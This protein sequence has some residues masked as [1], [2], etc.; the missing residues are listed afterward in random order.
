M[1]KFNVIT[2]FPNL[3]EEHFNNLFVSLAQI[4]IVFVLIAGILL[5]ILK[6]LKQKKDLY[7]LSLIFL[8][9]LGS[10]AFLS[11][12]VPFSL[13][14]L[15]LRQSSLLNQIFRA[16]L[17]KFIVPT[18][19]AFS[20][21]LAIGAQKISKQLKQK[22]GKFWFTLPVGLALAILFYA[23]PVFTGNLFYD[24]M[25]VTI[26]QDY[27][28][29]IEF[30]KDK[31]KNARIANLPQGGFWGWTFYRWGLRGSGFL[32]YGI[33][34][35]ILDRAFDVWS[36]KNEQYYWELNYALQKKDSNL[37][38]Q[39][40]IKYQVKYV[41]FDDNV[42][43]PGEKEYA[44]LSLSTK[45]LLEKSDQ[46]KKTISFG[47]IDLYELDSPTSPFLITPTL[48]SVSSANFYTKDP[49]FVR[50][51]HYQTDN[52]QPDSYYPFFNL[53]TNRFQTERDFE[54]KETK[55][56]WQ[57]IKKLPEFATVDNYSFVFNP[58]K[59]SLLIPSQDQE[60]FLYYQILQ[61]NNQL[62]LKIPKINSPWYIEKTFNENSQI[63]SESWNETSNGKHE[64]SLLKENDDYFV[65]LI[66][67]SDDAVLSF[68]FPNL[69]LKNSWLIEID[70]RWQKGLP[71][72]VYALGGENEYKFFSTKLEKTKDWRKAYFV[73]PP[74][75]DFGQGINLTLENISFNRHPSINQIKSVKIFPFPFELIQE[76]RFIKTG[77]LEKERNRNQ[78]TYPQ[79]NHFLWLYLI[80]NIQQ[81]TTL[82]LPQT[83]DPGW[84][85]IGVNHS[86][87][88]LFKHFMV[89]N[90]ANGWE[91][92]Q[93]EGKIIVFFWPQL[94]EFLGLLS[95]P[96][97]GFFLFK[98]K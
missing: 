45:K 97:L 63:K 5:V 15:L 55:Q 38:E 69:P 39:V 14:N 67:Q 92:N 49:A 87:F 20:C 24:Q 72:Y 98:R 53:F 48:P 90:W 35:P 11:D 9:L 26:P 6:T 40:F 80:N 60:T 27:F 43:F 82:V 77:N 18:I 36:L 64:A 68:N 25:K 33:E 4:F 56:D 73:I 58:I 74:Y 23:K 46:I 66:A 79:N 8:L 16:P 70:Y 62:V 50:S 89:D 22:T 21:F 13:T 94:L 32:W 57:L 52:K 10:V 41:L 81:P 88:K 96:V 44:K 84:L 17:T 85:A 30:F 54:I 71:P 7:L 93:G 61:E 86:Q 28:Q 65:N 19:F 31:D 78:V 51:G 3:F 12:T 47:E 37:L 59:Q 34:Q 1:L 42:F 83:F 29:L 76:A 75:S 2:L 91:I 95:L